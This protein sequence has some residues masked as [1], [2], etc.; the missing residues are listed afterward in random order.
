MLFEYFKFRKQQQKFSNLMKVMKLEGAYLIEDKKITNGHLLKVGIPSTLSFIDFEKKKEQLEARFKG[1][2]EL[3]KIRFTSMLT[4][5]IITK[6]VGVYD[7]APV[8]TKP[9]Q[10]YLGRLFDN[11]DYFLDLTKDPQ[12]LIA[13][14][15]GTGKSFLLAS[16][17]TNLIYNNSNNFELYLCQTAKRDIDYLKNCKPVKMNLYNPNE[18]AIALQKAVDEINRRSELFANN[19]FRGIDHYNSKNSKKL[20]RK[21]YVFEEISLYMPDDTDTEADQKEKSKVWTLIWKIVKLGRES[22]IHF[23]GLTQRTTVANLGGSGE[24]KSQ[25]TRITF[26]QSTELDSRNC[27]DCDLAK[28]LKDRECYVLGNQ[29]LQLIKV[30]NIDK[31]MTLLNKYVPEIIIYDEE[32]QKRSSSKVEE[33]KFSQPYSITNNDEKVIKLNEIT[34]KTN[35]KVKKGMVFDDND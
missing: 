20:K 19:G 35:K 5:K 12:I 24:I 7:F 31:E 18:T 26:R 27:I 33:V 29:G 3:E 25:L 22:G 13:G 23:I 21:V 8:R 11:T 1:I 2:I 34:K 10:V 14:V 30:P 32:K 4:M 6:D 28:D 16:I 17:L 9:T 15:T